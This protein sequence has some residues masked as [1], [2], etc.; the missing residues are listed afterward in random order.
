MPQLQDGN[1]CCLQTNYNS[2]GANAA[3]GIRNF[4]HV[5]SFRLDLNHPPTAVGGIRNFGHVLSF[6]LDLNPPPT[7][8]GGIRNLGHVLSLG[9]TLT[10]S[11]L[12]SGALLGSGMFQ[13]VGWMEKSSYNSGPLSFLV[14]LN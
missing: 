9:G 5:L 11:R 12:P 8:V 14:T 4:G 1:S 2:V 7:A 10:I 13:L 6:R 3:G